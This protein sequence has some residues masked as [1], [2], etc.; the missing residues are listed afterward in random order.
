MYKPSGAADKASSPP[1]NSLPHNSTWYPKIRFVREVIVVPYQT[2]WPIQ[3][4]EIAS[5]LVEVIRARGAQLE[6]IGSTAVPGLCAKPVLDVLLGVAELQ[7]I[8]ENMPHLRTLG[9]RY[10]PEYEAQL[11]ERRYFVRDAAALPRVHLHVVLLDG[12][13]WRAHIAFRDTLRRDESLARQ[14]AEL[15]WQLAK[16]YRH[17]KE[18]YTE[19]KAPFIRQIL[20]R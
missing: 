5:E 2:A 17:D 3:F 1:R 18:S 20:S 10:R 4:L 15:K 7:S 14:Y 11:P 16:Q 12:D 13:L 8:K 6:H 19:A 9:Y